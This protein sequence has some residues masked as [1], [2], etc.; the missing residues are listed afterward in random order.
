ME[1][2]PKPELM[3][4]VN[5]PFEGVVIDKAG[6]EPGRGVYICKNRACIENSIRKKRIKINLKTD[7][8][9][10]FIT[11]LQEYAATLE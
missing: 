8:S 3:R 1:R 5:S 2:K 9:E 4:I 10:S 11:L 7:I 6:K